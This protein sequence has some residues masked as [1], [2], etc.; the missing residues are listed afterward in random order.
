MS[1]IH[2]CLG[3]MNVSKTASSH[4]MVNPIMSGY[5]YTSPPVE[6]SYRRKDPDLQGSS[7]CSQTGN[8]N[9]GLLRRPVKTI[10]ALMGRNR[11]I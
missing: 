7:G 8:L 6:T 3:M 1:V 2:E 9:M 4:A 5:Q 11:M 10:L